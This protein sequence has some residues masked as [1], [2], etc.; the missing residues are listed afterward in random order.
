MQPPIADPNEAPRF[1]GADVR[2]FRVDFWFYFVRTLL[3][4]LILSIP[5]FVGF[6]FIA[7][8]PVDANFLLLIGGF[9]LLYQ[10]VLCLIQCAVFVWTVPVK[11]NNWGLR[12]FAYWGASR[13]APWSQITSVKSKWRVISYAVASVADGRQLWI[14]LCLKD[15]EQFA[16]SVAE[17]APLDH[18]LGAFLSGRDSSSH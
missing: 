2:V 10:I 4:S 3:A 8:P 13:E 1:S 16:E 15:K 11:V 7:R 12:A 6:V 18:P 5:L 17:F 14:P 9:A